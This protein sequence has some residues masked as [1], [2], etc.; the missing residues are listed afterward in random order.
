MDN[1]STLE[2]ELLGKVQAEKERADNLAAEHKSLLA[3]QAEMEVKFKAMEEEK[4][5]QELA[6]K[7]SAQKLEVE[8]ISK[9]F[10]D[11]YSA[12]LKGTPEEIRLQASE[13]QVKFNKARE[14]AGKNIGKSLANA[15][16]GVGNYNASDKAEAEK[17]KSERESK[18][19]ELAK[20]GP[21]NEEELALAML[22][23]KILFP[24]GR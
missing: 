15:P 21:R 14:D 10:P 3:K 18:R 6:A 5:K 2:K 8:K 1:D 4:A 22:N 17:L 20:T 23:T 7:E 19:I 24:V 12:T 16:V 13:Y 9:E 11:G